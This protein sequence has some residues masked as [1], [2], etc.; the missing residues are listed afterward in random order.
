MNEY[1]TAREYYNVS[2]QTAQE[3]ES[4]TFWATGLVRLSFL[5]IYSKSPQDALPLLLT[6]RKLVEP[7]GAS[8][9]LAWIASM[10]AEAYANLHD[11][12][13]CLQ[14]L[15]QVERFMERSKNGEDH[16]EIKFDYARFVGYK[17]VCH[18][19][20]RQAEAALSALNEGVTAVGT[21]SARQKS[22]IVAD[23]AAAYT[24][25]GEIEEA[26]RLAI[27]ALAMTDQT[28]SLL[29]SQRILDVRREMNQWKTSQPVKEFDTQ[30]V[31]RGIF[32]S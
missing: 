17:G 4:N 16:L 25:Q 18:L 3:A 32:P 10:E 27:Q 23:T 24:Q 19:R 12:H 29:A 22:I 21:L 6:A 5:P 1:A 15:G 26:C 28:K 13:A 11:E 20:L 31:L 7:R 30:L 8:A 14:V 2:I 9:I